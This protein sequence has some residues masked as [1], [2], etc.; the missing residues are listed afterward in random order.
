M[1]Y[2]DHIIQMSQLVQSKKGAWESIDPESVARMRV[3][4]RFKNGLEIARYNRRH[5]A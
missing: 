2:Q 4:N 3:Q 5:H 1:S